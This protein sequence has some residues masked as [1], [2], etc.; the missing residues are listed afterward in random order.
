M[1]SVFSRYWGAQP[2]P[3][4]RDSAAPQVLREALTGRQGCRAMGRNGFRYGFPP[5]LRKFEHS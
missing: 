5:T 2:A 1:I 4:R 3:D